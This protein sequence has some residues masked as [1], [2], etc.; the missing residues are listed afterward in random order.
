MKPQTP[1]KPKVV[2]GLADIKFKVGAQ[3]TRK[4]NRRGSIRK[5]ENFE[6][7]RQHFL[8]LGLNMSQGRTNNSVVL[9]NNEPRD[10]PLPN[11]ELSNVDN[12]DSRNLNAVPSNN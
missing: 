3:A 11:D 2:R 10:V 1:P 8:S 5:L 12:D 6:E 9:P 4:S 7:V